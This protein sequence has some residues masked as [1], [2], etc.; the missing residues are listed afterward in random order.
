MDTSAKPGVYVWLKTTH[1][2]SAGENIL[3]ALISAIAGEIRVLH[4]GV[5]EGDGSSTTDSSLVRSVY[6]VK[7]DE[8]ALGE[9][10][11]SSP[12]NLTN[13]ADMQG[14]V[15]G[16]TGDTNRSNCRAYVMPYPPEGVRWKVLE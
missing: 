13:L 9:R 10:A 8:E 4:L 5:R 14:A 7:I 1:K 12:I 15:N 2:K 11:A 3:N 6:V 16:A